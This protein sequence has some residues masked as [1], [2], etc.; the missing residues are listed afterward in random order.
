MF[1]CKNLTIDEVVI[2]LQENEI[3]TRND[4]KIIWAE[5]TSCEKNDKLIEFV[6]QRGPEAFGC[7]MKSLTETGQKNIFNKLIE[8]RTIIAEGENLRFA[9]GSFTAGKK[10]KINLEDKSAEEEKQ[11]K[12]HLNYALGEI[13][14]LYQLNH[15]R[16]I[17]FYG[18]YLDSGQMIIFM[19]A[20]IG[21]VKS[22]INKK[23]YLSEIEAMHYFIQAAEGLEFLHA[24]K[25]KAIIHRDIKCENLLLTAEN[26]V[27]LADFGLAID[28]AISSGSVTMSSTVPKSL[29]GTYF[30]IAPEITGRMNQSEA[31]SRK[32]DIWSLACTLVQMI[33]GEP[34][35]G[36][37][38]FFEFIQRS[39]PNSQN[40]LKY[41]GELLISTASHEMKKFLDYMFIVNY[42]LRPNAEKV[43]TAAHDA[44]KTLTNDRDIKNSFKDDDGQAVSYTLQQQQLQQHL[45]QQ[46]QKQQQVQ[47]DQRAIQQ[48]EKARQKMLK[49]EQ[50]ASQ[51]LMKLEEEARKLEETR[52]ELERQRMEDEEQRRSAG[53]LEEEA[54]QRLQK[55]QEESRRRME[56]VTQEAQKN[57]WQQEKRQREKET[58]RKRQEEELLRERQKG[59]EAERLKWMVELKKKKQST[60][61]QGEQKVQQQQ[62]QQQ[63]KV[64][65]D[66]HAIQREEA[67]QK[68]LKIEQEASQRL[69]KLEEEPIILEETRQEL[70]RQR[71]EDEEQRSSVELLED[72]VRRRLSEKQAESQQCEVQLSEEAQKNALQKQILQQEKEAVRKRQEEELRYVYKGQKECSTE[73]TL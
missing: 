9:D 6:Q 20:M 3:L 4:K 24:R 52:L 32:S 1:L 44:V 54:R 16:V 64:Q 67:G 71:M 28:L 30:F 48:E 60:S 21:S 37:L 51:R 39:S 43:L 68:M 27:K 65:A 38:S 41:S 46:Q 34:P 69:M 53:L 15:E 36:R 66:Q 7:F 12:K 42:K 18:F 49:T 57:A 72:E 62:L 2:L 59:E 14:M 17:K 70:E 31:Y 55:K 25:P 40:S 26:N 61:S 33:N 58:A 63:Q 5:K 47:V 56:Q 8:E 11:M 50:E 19:E 73:K 13:K 35:Y 23:M 22:E 45:L 29:T 10:P